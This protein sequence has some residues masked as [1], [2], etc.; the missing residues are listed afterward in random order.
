MSSIVSGSKVRVLVGS[1]DLPKG[2]IST[3]LEVHQGE[4]P[5]E[6][7]GSFACYAESELKQQ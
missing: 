6:V 5:F 3:V 7:Q 2:S 1:G 4:Y